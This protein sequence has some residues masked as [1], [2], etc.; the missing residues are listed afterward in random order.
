MG[1]FPKIGDWDEGRLQ[2][3]MQQRFNL[4]GNVRNLVNRAVADATNP[5]GAILMFG[6][7]AAPDGYLLCDGTSYVRTDYPALFTAIGTAY[8]SADATHFNVPDYREKMPVGLGTHADVNAL[9]DSGGT[10]AATH[11]H[12]T[13]ASTTAT[14]NDA[15][16]STPATKDGSGTEVVTPWDPGYKTHT[17][18]VAAGTSGATAAKPPWL[19]CQFIVKI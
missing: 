15:L 8:G 3:W 4:Q 16:L 9:G 10:W 5:S 13:P 17:H 6:G 2:A 1:L 7:A 12:S 14:R 11:T 19:T 18:D